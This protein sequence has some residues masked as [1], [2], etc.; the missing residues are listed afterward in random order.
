MKTLVYQYLI[1]RGHRGS[2]RPYKVEK[3]IRDKWIPSVK[4]WAESNNYDYKL[5][6]KLYDT[7]L[8][9]LQ[10]KLVMHKPYIKDYDRFIYL[11]IDIELNNP[12]ELPKIEGFMAIPDYCVATSAET[13]EPKSKWQTGVYMMDK[14]AAV[15]I[16]NGFYANIHKFPHNLV[17]Q[18]VLTIYFKDYPRY[19]M[20][21]H[22]WHW[23]HRVGQVP[24]EDCYFIH[25][26]K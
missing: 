18:E 17:D 9:I 7:N 26:C 1:G 11:D 21:N 10:N 6:T 8:S 15:D 12:P 14:Q 16:Y 25:H 5:I 4:R 19:K 24:K 2:P 20:L 3:H 22:R 13:Y 23:N